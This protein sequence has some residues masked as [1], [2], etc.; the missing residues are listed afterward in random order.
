MN[1]T[2]T[3]IL[4]LAPALAALLA[5]AHAAQ[6]TYQLLTDP[7]MVN[8]WPGIDGVIGTADDIIDGGS[9]TSGGSG[10]NVLG[11]LSQGSFDFGFP[12]DDMHL[13]PGYHAVTFVHNGSFVF[14]AAAGS[15]SPLIISFDI[16]SGSEPFVGHGPYSAQTTGPTSGTSTGSTFNLAAAPYQSLVSGTPDN[17]TMT[18]S[19][20][21]QVVDPNG[22]ATGD[23][24]LDTVLTPIA[25]ANNAVSYVVINGTGGTGT[26][27]IYGNIPVQYSL[28]GF[29]IVPE[30][31]SS[32]LL[33]TAFGA[34]LLRR[35]RP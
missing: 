31:S 10:P 3:A 28:I 35:R 11:A 15:S 29:E 2:L 23:N 30:P 17:A 16:V 12:V 1:R 5:P 26:D 27:S 34:G 22:A 13:A 7:S 24:Y 14:D 6:T 9:M 18:L 25:Q 21:Y 8:H 33:A 19:G 20:T 4:P 32:V